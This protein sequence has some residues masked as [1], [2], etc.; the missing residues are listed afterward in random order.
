MEINYKKDSINKK[1]DSNLNDLIKINL[2][3]NIESEF[4]SIKN[5]KN[6]KDYL[7]K[8]SKVFFSHTIFK[9]CFK[10]A[11]NLDKSS[12]RSLGIFRYLE[13]FSDIS[14]LRYGLFIVILKALFRLFRKTYNIL[15][16]NK[17]VLE[18]KRLNFIFGLLANIIL[19]PI[20]KKSSLTFITMLY[21]LLRDLFNYLKD[22]LYLSNK[23][24]FRESKNIYYIGVS[25]GF[26]LITLLN[27]EYRKSIKIIY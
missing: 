5:T 23:R 4:S 10:I 13:I 25:L 6:F 8:Y 9:V 18:F 19:I 11:R 15:N 3:D 24:N 1:L 22:H 2:N 21:F 17:N 26:V 14:N 16:L 20:G 27:S 7:Y 12:N